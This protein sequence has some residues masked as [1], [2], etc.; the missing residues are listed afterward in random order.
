M[1]VRSVQ[2]V[3]LACVMSTPTM[4]N[5]LDLG[6][7]H[8]LMHSRSKATQLHMSHLGDKLPC[9]AHVL[10]GVRVGVGA[11]YSWHMQFPLQEVISVD[12]FDICRTFKSYLVVILAMNQASLQQQ[13]NGERVKRWSNMLAFIAELSAKFLHTISVRMGCG[14]CANKFWFTG[15]GPSA[16]VGRQ[17]MGDG[18]S[19]DGRRA[20]TVEHWSATY[21]TWEN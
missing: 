13:W 16:S 3:A 20:D 4:Y 21:R 12:G 9:I 11:C 2:T 14:G 15:W 5:K 18:W 1:G 10:K 19:A 17:C 8:L 7:F 6:C